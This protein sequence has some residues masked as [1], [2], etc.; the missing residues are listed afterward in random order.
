MAVRE[1]TEAVNLCLPNGRLNRD[2]AGFTRT[3]L[4]ESNLRGWG[5]NKRWDYWGIVSPRFVLGMTVASLD[6]AHASQLYLHDRETGKT[7]AADSATIGPGDVLVPDRRP[8]M[9]VMEDNHKAKLR[10][11]DESGRTV[12][13]A[14]SKHVEINLSVAQG[15]DCLGVVVPWSDR[16]FQ[17]TL[18]ELAR[19]VEGTIEVN[20]EAFTIGPDDAFAVL[21][22]GR[23]KWPYKM[24][25]N[26]AAGSG[27][28]DGKRIGLQ[29]GGRWTKGTGVADNGLFVDGHLSYW[30]DELEWTYSLAKK[31]SPW[32]V[33][34]QNVDATL[35]PFHRRHASTNYGIVATSAYQAFGVWS[36]SAVDDEGTSHSLDGLTGWAEQAHNRW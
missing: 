14:S 34:G 7:F 2:A 22:R 25:W 15:G 9:V 27:I 17:Y 29:M 1:I 30:D 4:H 28:V 3:P 19:P 13:R 26:W 20:G 24:S 21:D 10:F 35:T 11:L 23:G 18:K 33:Q 12:L 6:Y 8:P 5:R 16:R 32:R 36:G 31:S